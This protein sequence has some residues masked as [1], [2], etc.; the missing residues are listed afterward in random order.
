MLRKPID[1]L[2]PS[3]SSV[4]FP[5]RTATTTYAVIVNMTTIKPAR[6]RRF[7]VGRL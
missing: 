4:F 7:I 6:S 3:E 1:M 5:F 2:A